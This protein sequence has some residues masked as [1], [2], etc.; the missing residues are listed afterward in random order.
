[1][2]LV[3]QAV[4]VGRVE[5]RVQN[6]V[7]QS[8][9]FGCLRQHVVELVDVGRGSPRRHQ[10][11]DGVTEATDDQHQLAESL[12]NDPFF[13][14]IFVAF[15]GV[16]AVDVI[17]AGVTGVKTAGVAGGVRDHAAAFEHTLDSAV[18]QST[19]APKPQQSAAGLLERG[20]VRN[21]VQSDGLP[22]VGAMNNN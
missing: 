20:E 1:M 21:T 10:S 6:H 9:P 12:V 17:A 15:V 22:Q 14:A 13:R 16:A 3:Q 4:V 19:H 5:A 8:Q 7:P 2:I 18:E 11:H